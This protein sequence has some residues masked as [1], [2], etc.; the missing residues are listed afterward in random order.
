MAGTVS[1]TSNT[2][3][4]TNR[5]EGEDIWEVVLSY[6]L[7][8]SSGGDEIKHALPVNGILQ[9]II[10]TSGAATGITGTF[11]LAI[12]DNGDNEIFTASGP[13]EGATST[14]NVA[15]PVSGT[16]DIGV[17]PNDDPTSGTWTITVTLRGI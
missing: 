10:A 8:S 4:A 5:K 2:I 6:V 15:E 7:T 3:A 11:T 14:W 16:I 17:N 13:A 12:D 9:K 1:E